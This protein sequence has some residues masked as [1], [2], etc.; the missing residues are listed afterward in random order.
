[1]IKTTKNTKTD[2]LTIAGVTFTAE[3]QA[4]INRDLTQ[5][6]LEDRMEQ[7]ELE[8]FQMMDSSF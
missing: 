4:E 5:L 7:A 3:E 8:W 2:T 6:E 1:M